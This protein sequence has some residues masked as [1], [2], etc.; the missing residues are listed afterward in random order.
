MLRDFKRD[1]AISE[2]QEFNAQE[3]LQKLTDRFIAEADE[4]G[5]EKER[6]VMEV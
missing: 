2:D 1:K 3:E 6:E 5:R 4:L